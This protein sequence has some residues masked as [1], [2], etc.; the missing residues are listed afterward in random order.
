MEKL[1]DQIYKTEKSILA[2]LCVLHY[3]TM[4]THGNPTEEKLEKRK[5]LRRVAVNDR[6]RQII[7]VDDPRERYWGKARK[8]AKPKA[9]CRER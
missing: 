2:H 7:Y 6:G 3:T 5:S 8:T 4:F 9:G 1:S